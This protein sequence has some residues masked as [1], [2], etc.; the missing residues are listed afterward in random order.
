MQRKQ[1]ARMYGIQ[2][3]PNVLSVH[4]P[5]KSKKSM[6]N[7]MA[8]KKNTLDWN[9]PIFSAFVLSSWKSSNRVAWKTAKQ[10]LNYN[11]SVQMITILVNEGIRN[12]KS[13]TVLG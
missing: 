10:N 11:L 7:I 4:Q 2:P 1:A 8:T 5:R 13:A 6:W 9:R 12:D 3:A